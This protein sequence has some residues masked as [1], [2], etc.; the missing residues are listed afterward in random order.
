MPEDKALQRRQ[1]ERLKLEIEAT[2]PNPW[3]FPTGDIF[4]NKLPGNGVQGFLG[5]GPLMVV[6]ERPSTG[7]FSGPTDFLLYRVLA[8]FGAANCHLTDVIKS[9]GKVNE[10]YPDKIGPHRR[11]FDKEL[12]IVKPHKIIA[13]GQKVHDLLL[14]SLAG[15]GIKITQVWH[16]AY[17]GRWGKID[18]FEAKMRAA[19]ES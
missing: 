8:K 7:K 13:L 16:Y 14:F 4:N 5:T 9:R 11:V 1:L 19:I 6:G 15:S 12:E 3:F 18:E 17:A 2:I 10:P